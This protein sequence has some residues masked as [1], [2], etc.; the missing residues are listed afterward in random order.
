MDDDRDIDQELK[1]FRK[2]IERDLVKRNIDSRN[3][4]RVFLA[5]NSLIVVLVLTSI[6]MLIF[7]A[8]ATTA[9]LVSG[10]CSILISAINFFQFIGALKWSK[11][12]AMVLLAI[13]IT[14]MVLGITK[15]I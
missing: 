11:R 1:A 13:S 10:A 5:L 14:N 2:K 15:F 9:L 6:V 8:T 12:W 7:P 3:R 4:F